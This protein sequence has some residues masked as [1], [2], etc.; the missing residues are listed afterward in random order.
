MRAARNS[1]YG[2]FHAHCTISADA[3]GA[4]SGPPDA[5]YQHARDVAGID[6]QALTDH[7]HYMTASEYSLLLSEANNFT[8][9]NVFVAIA[10][11]EHGSLSTSVTGAFGH[12]NIW[13]FTGVVNQGI[14]RYDLPATYGLVGT[15]NDRFG[16]PLVAGFNHPGLDH[17]QGRLP[18]REVVR[19]VGARLILEDVGRG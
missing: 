15:N 12:I 8:Q 9:N 19:L 16:N 5:A 6:I 4:N 3:Q 1:D 17:L 2:N 13:E 11:Q 10:G 14:F 18:R 7:S